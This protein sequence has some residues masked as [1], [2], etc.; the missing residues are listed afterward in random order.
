MSRQHQEHQSGLIILAIAKVLFGTT[1]LFLKLVPTPIILLL[2]A[3][4]FCGAVGFLP[5]AWSELRS[6]RWS[7]LRLNLLVAAA[8]L[9]NDFSY[10]FAVRLIDVSLATL[11]RWIAPVLLASLVFFA[12]QHKNRRALIAAFVGFGGL[13]LVLTSKGIVYSTAN[14]MGLALALLS[15]IAV[16]FYWY[17]SK[18]VL[19]HMSAAV[20]L[21][22]RSIT[23][24]PVLVIIAVVGFRNELH[25]NLMT[26]LW[27]IMFGL[28]YGIAAGYLDTLGIQRTKA[29]YLGIIG[30]LVPLTTLLGAVVILHE[31]LTWVMVIGGVLILGSGYWAQRTR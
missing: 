17:S 30:Y 14:A 3:Q 7:D 1:A 31:S 26:L 15:A 18:I 20:L 2:L 27:M 23:A 13:F 12:A 28:L 19:Q 16:T 21:W 10:Y 25:I 6:L 11:V 22:L 9:L 4:S 8:F 24:L 5:K 29:E